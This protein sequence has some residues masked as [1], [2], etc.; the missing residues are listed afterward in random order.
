[1]EPL[2][3]FPVRTLWTLALNNALIGPPGFDGARGYFP[4][5]GERLV[6]YDLVRG[7]QLWI[8]QAPTIAQP[9]S[10]DGLVF[11][12]EPDAIVALRAQDGS[13]AWR[14][15]LLEPLAVRIVWGNGWL[16]ASTVSGS[17]LAFRALDGDLI[18]TRNVGARVS[19]PPSLAADRMYVPL[20]D[21]RIVALQVQDGQPVWERR[22]GGVPSDG[23][24]L[25]DRVY[26]GSDDNFL[27]CLKTDKGQID[28]RWRTGADVAGTPVVDEARVYFVSLDNVL[29]GLNRKSGA[30]Q[31]KRALPM[32]PKSGPLLVANALLVRGI[33]PTLRAYLALDGAPA[34][35]VT[36]SGELVSPPHLVAGTLLPTLIVVTG[37]LVKGATVTALI[38][39]IEPPILP[40]APL[41]NPTMPN[42]SEFGSNSP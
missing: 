10:G 26:F 14:R 37:D 42:P 9:V 8:V 31:W 1:M 34:G 27:Y 25:D 18:W 36:L 28:W 32:R 13:Q 6:A 2:S 38:R 12:V 4:I 29:R 11:Y 23:L 17:I 30:Q 40:L 19:A 7:E 5:E 24:A 15:P 39:A 20:A 33:A 21:R 41:P 35:E 22:L 3:L 16:I